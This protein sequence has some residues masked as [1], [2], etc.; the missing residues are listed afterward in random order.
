MPKRKSCVFLIDFLIFSVIITK[1][2]RKI[3]LFSANLLFYFLVEPTT[4]PVYPPPP[5]FVGYNFLPKS[6]IHHKKS[7]FNFTNF[8]L[9]FWIKKKVSKILVTTQ[10]LFCG[11][12]VKLWFS[13]HTVAI[14]NEKS[15][16]MAYLK[17]PFTFIVK[18]A[19]IYIA[20]Y[21]F[22]GKWYRKFFEDILWDYGNCG[23][24]K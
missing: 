15:K 12:I 13:N 16:K 1:A 2:D 3:R 19:N 8:I 18:L 17:K 20:R 24:K 5:P 7:Y 14:L 21:E 9:V 10:A 23:K 4:D 22:F 11:K 6:S